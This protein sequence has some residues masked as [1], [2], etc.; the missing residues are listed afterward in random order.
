MYIRPT[1]PAGGSLWAIHA[2]AHF[3][4]LASMH[5]GSRPGVC[6]LSGMQVQPLLPWRS[7]FIEPSA[8]GWMIVALAD[9]DDGAAAIAFANG[10]F[11]SGFDFSLAWPSVLAGAPLWHAPSGNSA[12]AASRTAHFDNVMVPSTHPV[13]EDPP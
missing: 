2:C 8:S 3:R 6:G 9:T 7:V 12:A 4:P 11:E 5:I 10:S 1:A 13:E